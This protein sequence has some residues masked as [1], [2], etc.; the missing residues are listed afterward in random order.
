M[1]QQI[2]Q[3]PLKSQVLW[4]GI[5]CQRGI[6]S[7]LIDQAIE[8]V[9]LEYQLADYAIAG[10]ATID[11][12]AS[13]VGLVEFCRL[14]SLPL[15]TFSAESLRTVLV[16]NP[17]KIVQETTG[18]PSVAEAAAILAVSECALEVKL[19]VPKQIFRL[20]GQA[21]TITVAVAQSVN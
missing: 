7:Q 19:L 12:K 3:I 20:P 18:T 5:G 1:N 4:V 15:K 8:K 14:R 11:A 13:E 6:S 17:A 16:P 2:L 9:F 21:G 10:F